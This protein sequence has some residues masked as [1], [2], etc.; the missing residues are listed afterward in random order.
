MNTNSNTLNGDKRNFEEGYKMLP[1]GIQV[2]VRDYI[3]V[4][5]GWNSV[6]TFHNKRKGLTRIRPVEAEAI[7]RHFAVYGIDPWTGAK[8]T[9][10]ASF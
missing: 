5:C 8:I 6:P 7:E 3:M 10:H 4:A 2:M 9:D 1:A